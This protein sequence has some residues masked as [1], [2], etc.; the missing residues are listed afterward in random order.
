MKFAKILT[1]QNINMASKHP[2]C[3]NHPCFGRGS[4][5]CYNS[6]KRRS[7]NAMAAKDHQKIWRHAPPRYMPDNI[8]G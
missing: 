1:R 7:D 8:K 6:S 5:L 4:D 3:A 2:I